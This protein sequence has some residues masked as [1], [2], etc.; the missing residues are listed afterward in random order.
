MENPNLQVDPRIEKMPAQK[1]ASCASHTHLELLRTWPVL[2][3]LSE[4]EVRQIGITR[5]ALPPPCLSQHLT[6]GWHSRGSCFELASQSIDLSIYRTASSLSPR[7]GKR[8]PSKTCRR[9]PVFGS[10]RSSAKDL[11]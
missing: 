7:S 10:Q 2:S 11:A 4:Q 5:P 3:L 8:L 6:C 9:C 1:L